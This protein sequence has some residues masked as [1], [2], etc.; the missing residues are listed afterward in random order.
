M[1]QNE[2]KPSGYRQLENLR[3]EYASLPVPLEAR[4]RI[5]KG[6]ALGKR[7]SHSKEFPPLPPQKGVI[8]MKLIKR[9]GMTAAAAM[10]AITILANI[11]PTIANAMEQIPVIGPISKVVTFRTYEN[12]TD[13]FEA[14]VQ[15]PQEIGRASCRERVFRAV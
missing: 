12:N 6:I 2:F 7:A 4:E 13:N 15:I 9:T 8:F 10:M 3:Q 14:N 5:L 11:D 1:D